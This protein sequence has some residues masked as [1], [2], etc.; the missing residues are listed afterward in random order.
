MKQCPN[1]ST[2]NQDDAAFCENCGTDL[3]NVAPAPVGGPGAPRGGSGAAGDF[4]N[5]AKEAAAEGARKAREAAAAVQSRASDPGPGGWA[6]PQ[7]GNGIFVDQSESI[8]ATIG[9]SYLQNFLSGGGVSK[10]IGIL[11]QKRF[12]YKGRNFSGAGK[13]MRSTTQEG[14]VS[15]DDIA[16]SQFTYT[17]H[18]GLLIF[19]ILLTLAAVASVFAFQ[20]G[21]EQI[22]LVL[23]LAA[24]VFYVLYFTKRQTLFMVSFP[25]GGFAFD[26][27]RYPIADIR[28]FQRQLHLL[29]DRIK[30][31]A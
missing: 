24:I 26:V 23:A 14:V 1:C 16:F 2:Q 3:R 28:D 12:Y 30:E 17:R 31:N 25:G 15:I 7:G 18:I 10:G 13:A 5:K 29:K 4:F 20:Y 19:A 21:G 6:A 11:T 8:V 22:A 9:N 27:R